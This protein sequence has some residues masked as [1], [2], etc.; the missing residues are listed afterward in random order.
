MARLGFGTDVINECLNH[1]QQ[2][3][4]AKVYIRDRRQEAQA[5]AFDALGERL[6]VLLGSAKASGSEA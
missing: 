3:R 6:G 5:Q 2:D 1:M 4:M